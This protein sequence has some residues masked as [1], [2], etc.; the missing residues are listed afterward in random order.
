MSYNTTIVGATVDCYINGKLYSVVTSFRWSS[1]TS[2]RSIHGID[3]AEPLELAPTITR[4]TGSVGLLRSHMDAGIEGVGVVA[5]L[6]DLSREKYFTIALMDRM[7]GTIIFKADNC[8]V[9]NQSWDVP[10]RG[11]VTG[12]MTF[13]AIGWGNEYKK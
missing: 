13:E 2:R 7:T 1:D 9:M 11:M 6:Q 4:V 3:S 5:P 10:A 8:S 12:Q